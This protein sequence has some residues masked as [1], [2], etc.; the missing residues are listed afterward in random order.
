MRGAN[1]VFD[2]HDTVAERAELHAEDPAQG[3]AMGNG[4]KEQT[5]VSPPLPRALGHLD[6]PPVRTGLCGKWRFSGATSPSQES[7]R[8]G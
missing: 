5:N 8:L 3:Q 2:R 6:S 1:G 4:Q 7:N